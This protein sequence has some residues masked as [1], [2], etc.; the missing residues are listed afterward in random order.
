MENPLEVKKKRTYNKKPKTQM[1]EKQAIQIMTRRRAC[2][3]KWRKTLLSKSRPKKS[4]TKKRNN[5]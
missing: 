2:I 1:T 5:G 3:Q 4:T